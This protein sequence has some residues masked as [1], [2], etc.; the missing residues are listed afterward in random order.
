M[1]KRITVCLLFAIFIFG[2]STKVDLNTE[3]R[4]TTIVFGLMDQNDEYHYVKINKAFLGPGNYYEYAL[5]RD[6]SEY[7]LV[8]A[9]VEELSNGVVINTY[10]LRDTELT[11]RPTTGAFFAPNQTV[12]YFKKLGLNPAYTYRLTA[13]INE[14]MV[15]EKEV[16]SETSLI[17]DF[18]LSGFASIS[19]GSYDGSTSTYTQPFVKFAP[20]SNSNTYEIIWRLKWDEYSATDTVRKKYDWLIG[21][22][23]I[24]DLSVAGLIEYQVNGEAFFKTLASVIP[25]DPTIVKR[26]FRAVDVV[27]YAASEDLDTYISVTAPQSGLVQERPEFTNINNGLGLFSSR[28]HVTLPNKYLTLGGMRELCHGPYTGG[29]LFCT[30]TT[31]TIYTLCSAPFVVCP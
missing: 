31:S 28:L 5:I 17:Q 16:S 13:N 20:P 27:V 30:D 22:A 26:V 21:K 1:F 18:N 7:P 3:W 25:N 15:N 10:T 23:S 6:S 4:D 14:G 11:D 9:K 24:N 29:L 8:N 2:C 19:V 12:Y